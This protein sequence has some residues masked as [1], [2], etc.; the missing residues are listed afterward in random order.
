[1]TIEEVSLNDVDEIAAM[2]SKY[3]YHPYSEA[4]LKEMLR[5]PNCL[6]L[7]VV[8]NGETAG[9]ASGQFVVDE[10]NMNNIVIKEKFRRMGLAT[11]LMNEIVNRCKV[12]KAKKVYLEV[13]QSNDAAL[14]LY[15]KFGFKFL[16]ERKKYYGDENALVLIM[17][18]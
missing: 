9:Y 18:I 12:E 2:E 7:K 10:F 3:I 11:A 6:A 5:N 17:T 8:E 16:Y 4:V 14:N 13:A 15:Y 1:M